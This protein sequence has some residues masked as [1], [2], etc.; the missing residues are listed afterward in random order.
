MKILFI[1][2]RNINTKVIGITPPLGL[3]YVASYIR[4]TRGDDVR[5]FDISFHKAP[6][7]EIDRIIH[8][9]EP[10]VIGISALTLEAPALYQIAHFVKTVTGAPI[11]VGGP[12]ATSAPDEILENKDIDIAVIGEGEVTFKEL[13]D[14]LDAGQG[15]EK[16]DGIMYRQDDDIIRTP[17]RGYIDNLNE[18][19]FPAWD[20]I[21]VNKYAHVKSVSTIIFRSS[22]LPYMVMLTSRGCPF[23][24]TFCHNIMGKNFRARSAENVLEEMRILVEQY[25][26]ND[27]EIIDD[28]SNF[29]RERIKSILSGIIEK[30]WKVRL[31]FSNGV[32][33]DMLDE[34][35]ISLMQKAGASEVSIAVE[36]VSPRLQKMIK[37][38]LNL[39]KVK[40]M[41]EFAAD[42]G[43]FLRG[44]FM[45]GFPTETEEEM[46]ATIDFACKSKL[47]IAYFFL[48]NPYKGTGIY[49]YVQE[50]GLGK[51]LEKIQLD[52]FDYLAMPLN[53]SDIPDEKFYKLYRSAYIKFY[54]NP[55][56]IFRILRTKAVVHDLFYHFN[57][58]LPMVLLTLQAMLFPLKGNKQT[59]LE[60]VEITY[61]KKNT[62]YLSLWSSKKKQASLR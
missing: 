46:K 61:H 15:I 38:N 2:S 44:F 4:A 34:E 54:I 55:A 7:R 48:L 23:Q 45:F 52:D 56:R 28:I 30:G 18:L 11:I 17:P 24:C 26:I 22:F 58:I 1:K 5:I 19:P 25:H 27:F 9:F 57:H 33:T 51:Q 37:K 10:D 3:M 59:T 16:V 12:H 43:I 62:K 41:I 20:L 47:H 36:T 21:D 50:M 49:E 42:R 14:N 13:L 35:I 60:Q 8:E 29:D 6:L 31:S 53:I 32:R 39:E 40:K